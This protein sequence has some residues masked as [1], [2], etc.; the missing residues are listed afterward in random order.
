MPTPS[1]PRPVPGDGKPSD[2]V[3]GGLALRR[4]A[5]H[6]A[7]RL[8]NGIRAPITLNYDRYA[9]GTEAIF[10]IYDPREGWRV[11]GKGTVSPDGKHIV[12]ERGVALHQTMGGMYSVPGT[13][14]PTRRGWRPITQGSAVAVA[15]PRLRAIRLT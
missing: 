2:G 11:Y 5:A 8:H 12:P 15:V 10:W 9:A 13:N 6:V 1:E 14:G 3:H 7:D 4:S